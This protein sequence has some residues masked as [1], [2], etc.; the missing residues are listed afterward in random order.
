MKRFLTAHVSALTLVLIAVTA[1][2]ADIVS[3]DQL[4]WT[5][6]FAPVVPGTHNALPAVTADPKPGGG[7]AGVT[8]TNELTQT[9]TGSSDVVATNLRVFSSSAAGSPDT[10]TY[11]GNPGDSGAYGL[12]LTI[13][14]PDGSK[15]L[16]FTGGLSTMPGKGF[17]AESANIKN[18]F[19]A[20]TMEQTF[21]L[22]NYTFTVTMQAYTPPGPPTQANAGSISA[23]VGVTGLSPGGIGAPEPGTMVLSCLGLSFLGGAAWRKRR[24]VRAAQAV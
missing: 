14:T 4:S 3:P 2:P 24:Q 6:N 23:H 5:Y 19:D 18:V 21:S 15:T 1:A 9:A 13:S 12:M 20:A 8:F 7:V 17:S 10:L 16:T 22:G 11:H